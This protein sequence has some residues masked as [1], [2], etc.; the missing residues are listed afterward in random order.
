MSVDDVAA[1]SDQRPIF[2]RQVQRNRRQVETLLHS[3]LVAIIALLMGLNTGGTHQ[4]PGENHGND[5]RANSHEAFRLALISCDTRPGMEAVWI[6]NP[7]EIRKL[8]L[9]FKQIP[10]SREKQDA[11]AEERVLRG[12]RLGKRTP[13]LGKL[14][15]KR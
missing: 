14:R 15:L 13:R 4:G 2:S 5:N 6:C 8:A 9:R 11:Q 7:V 10:I 3:L 12:G 1:S